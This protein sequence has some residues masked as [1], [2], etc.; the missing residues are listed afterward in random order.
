ML[1]GYLRW[2]P[3]RLVNFRRFPNRLLGNGRF[4][5]YLIFL[6]VLIEVVEVPI[7]D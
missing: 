2:L 1:I 3:D 4:F 7:F 6:F 5:D